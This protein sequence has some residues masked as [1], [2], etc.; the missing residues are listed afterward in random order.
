MFN[1]I[2]IALLQTQGFTILETPDAFTMMTRDTFLFDPHLEWKHT[3]RALDVAYP[4][5]RIG[6]LIPSDI[7]W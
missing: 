2:D 3:V 4:S 7:S 5:L 1:H 6:N